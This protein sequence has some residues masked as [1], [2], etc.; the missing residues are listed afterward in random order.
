MI[1]FL[2]RLFNHHKIDDLKRVMETYRVRNQQLED[3]LREYKG[4]KLKYQVA[5]LYIEDDE[6]ILEIFEAAQ[7]VEDNKNNQTLYNQ[8]GLQ[9]QAAAQQQGIGRY[10]GGLAGFIGQS[11]TGGC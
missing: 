2:H 8:L 3:E 5:Q 9:Q 11:L 1:K 10:T 7:K 6:A 4:Y